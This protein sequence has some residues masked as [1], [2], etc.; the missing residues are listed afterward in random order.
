MD[1]ANNHAAIFD[2]RTM[3]NRLGGMHARMH[4]CVYW[5]VCVCVCVCIHPLIRTQVSGNHNDQLLFW[6]ECKKR[7]TEGTCDVGPA[8]TERYLF[9]FLFKHND[10]TILL[11][12]R[13]C[14][15]T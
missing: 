14:S 9:V 15:L 2:C 11:T 12:G 3:C 10:I 1:S 6:I 5:C 7:E 4:G 8:H 13:L